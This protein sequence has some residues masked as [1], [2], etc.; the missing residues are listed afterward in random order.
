M[1]H[2]TYGRRIS[3]SGGGLSR[4]GLVGGSSVQLRKRDKERN[5]DVDPRLRVM[6]RFQELFNPDNRD[7]H[8]CSKRADDR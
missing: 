1:A 6:E 4:G 5:Q 8:T 7:D 3:E 2:K